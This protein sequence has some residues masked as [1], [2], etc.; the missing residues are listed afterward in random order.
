MGHPGDDWPLPVTARDAFTAS[1]K[2][3]NEPT[4]CHAFSDKTVIDTP[5]DYGGYG[6]FDATVILRGA[7]TQN[8]VAAFQSRILYQGSGTLEN[9]WGHII[10]PEATG[11]GNILANV[12]VQIRGVATT[13]AAVQS[14]RGI[15]IDPKNAI[16]ENIGV[17]VKNALCVNTPPVSFNSM[18]DGGG[19]SF[20]AKNM[21]ALYNAGKVFFGDFGDNPAAITSFALNVKE[22][23][24]SVSGA[25]SADSAN[26]AF[27]LASGDSRVSFISNSALLGYW[28]GTA[29]SRAFIANANTQPLGTVA[30][31]WNTA[32]L[33]SAPNVSSDARL[34]DFKEISDAEMSCAKAIRAHIRKYKLKSEGVRGKLHFGVAAQTIF[35]IFEKHGLSPLDYRLIERDESGWYSVSYEE[36]LCFMMLGV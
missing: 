29:D 34:K 13:T 28:G 27:I 30:K 32:Y 6:S 16:Q 11:N 7:H 2:I 12:G 20:Y 10:W 4:D 18:Q 31:R 5:S 36:L 1:R 8:H 25:F 14:N 26:G 23:A 3:N 24:S 33:I 9:L 19:Y 17:L 35:D 15:D 21:G 22:P